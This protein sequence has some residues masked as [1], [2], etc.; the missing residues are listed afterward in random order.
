MAKIPETESNTKG[1]VKEIHPSGKSQTTTS[2][3]FERHQ[4][5]DPIG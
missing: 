1:D 5:S 2:L 4:E 3:T